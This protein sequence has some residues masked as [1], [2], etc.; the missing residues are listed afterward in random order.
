MNH[1]APLFPLFHFKKVEQNY[2]KKWKKWIINYPGF[3]ALFLKVDYKLSWF[4]ST[5]S[6]SG[7]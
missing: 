7:L 1:F 2:F 6:K 5:F 4:C 3:A